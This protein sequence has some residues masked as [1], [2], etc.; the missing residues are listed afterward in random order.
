MPR[1][2]PISSTFDDVHKRPTT[3][4][5][6]GCNCPVCAPP[7]PSDRAFHVRAAIETVAYLAAG[8]ISAWIVDRLVDG[9]G[10]QIMWGG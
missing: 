6:F 2:R 5:L 8:G 3:F 9:P 1:V 10:I 4:H 7:S